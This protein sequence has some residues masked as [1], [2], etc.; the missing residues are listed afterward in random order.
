M[1]CI[2]GANQWKGMLNTLDRVSNGSKRCDIIQNS[3][4]HGWKTFYPLNQIDVR[5]KK[6]FSVKRDIEMISEND[7]EKYD[8]TMSGRSF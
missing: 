6:D 7:Y 1:K 2:R 5:N 3:I 8:H 4:D